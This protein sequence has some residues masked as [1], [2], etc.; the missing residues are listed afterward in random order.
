VDT[1]TTQKRDERLRPPER[2]QT[3]SQFR[4]VLS[5]GRCYR[6]RV[7]RVH[8]VATE[9]EFSRLGLVVSRRLGCAVVRTRLKRLLREAFRRLKDRLPASHDVVVYPLDPAA[10]F[11]DYFDALREFA[12]WLSSHAPS[13]PR[14]EPQR[15]SR[16][17]RDS[18]RR[19]VPSQILPSQILPSQILPSQILSSQV[20]AAAEA[21]PAGESGR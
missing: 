12:T 15:R 19:A 13:P 1:K 18:R 4:W 10:G 9:R 2:L 7:V 5:R 16:R 14:G 11:E 20:G 17:R 21:R 8:T 6:G 3:A